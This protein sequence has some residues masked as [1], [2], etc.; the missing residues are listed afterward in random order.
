MYELKT[1]RNDNS[2]IAFIEQVDN[3]K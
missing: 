2:E 3:V 1:K